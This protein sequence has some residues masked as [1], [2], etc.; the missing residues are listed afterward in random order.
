MSDSNEMEIKMIRTRPGMIFQTAGRE[1]LSQEQQEE[2]EKE[3]LTR[4][5]TY[6]GNKLRIS[7]N[8]IQKIETEWL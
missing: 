3:D 6:L 4:P 1:F 7:G 5:P 2:L 8:L